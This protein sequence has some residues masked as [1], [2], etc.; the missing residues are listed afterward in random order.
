MNALLRHWKVKGIIQKALSVAPGGA[1]VNDVLQRRLG[2]LRDFDDNIRIKVENWRGLMS[3]LAK[4]GAADLAG[5][6]IMEIGSGWYPTVPLC[7]SLAGVRSC[8]TVDISRHMSAELVFRMYR[9]VERHLDLIGA[10]SGCAPQTIRARYESLRADSLE[11]FLSRAGIMYHA[12]ADGSKASWL[13][14]GSIDLVYSNSVLEHVPEV[15]IATLMKES[16]RILKTGGLMLHAVACNDHYAHFDKS[17]SYINYLQFTGGQWRLWNND[18]NYQ[19]RLRANDF[20]RLARDSGFEIVHETRVV[21]PGTRE[22]VDHLHIAPEFS[23]YSREDLIA[24]TVDFI[25][26]KPISG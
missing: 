5:T 1:R 10:V 9:A 20:I 24:T 7:F 19:N 18:L 16:R 11:D 14:D 23:S 2:D 21:R 4:V 8:H 22:A 3:Y 6:Q 13:A 12:P 25:G 17:I 15:V 26:R